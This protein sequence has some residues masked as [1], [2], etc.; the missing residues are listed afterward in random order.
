MSDI[1][2]EIGLLSPL[3]SDPTQLPEEDDKFV[4]NFQEHP[5][6]IILTDSLGP[7]LQRL[8]PDEQ[9]YWARSWHLL[10]KN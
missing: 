9:Y 4:K 6:S 7:I 3:F 1:I 8:H 2:S 5:Q 10:E